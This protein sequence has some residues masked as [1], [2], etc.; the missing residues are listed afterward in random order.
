MRIV[1]DEECAVLEKI[2]SSGC[3]GARFEGEF[4]SRLRVY[5]FNRHDPRLWP[6]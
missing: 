6:T 5:R 1:I 2:V 4:G 3:R